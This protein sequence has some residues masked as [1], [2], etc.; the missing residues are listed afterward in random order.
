[1][2]HTA[3]MQWFLRTYPKNVHQYNH[4]C[5]G[6]QINY[7]CHAA[8]PPAAAPPVATAPAAAPPAA[9]APAASAP[10]AMAPAAAPRS[11]EAEQLADM[12][13]MFEQGLMEASV[14][15]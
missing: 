12:K 3:Q 2:S 4:G 6:S 13:A 7:H 11:S 5:S 1:M 15:A 9:S 14:R 8:T 10:A